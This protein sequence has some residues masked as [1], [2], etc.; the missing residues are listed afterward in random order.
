M[1]SSPQLKAALEAA[2]FIQQDLADFL[3]CSRSLVTLLLGR[4]KKSAAKQ[5]RLCEILGVDHDTLF[6]P[7]P[8]PA[9]EFPKIKR[10]ITTRRLE[11][12]KAAPKWAREFVGMTRQFS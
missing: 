9:D 3:G 4:K 8:V 5:K 10:Q 11:R 6:G 7:D 2:D 1:L 12:Q